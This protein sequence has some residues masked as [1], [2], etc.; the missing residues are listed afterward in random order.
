MDIFIQKLYLLPGLFSY[1][2]FLGVDLQVKKKIVLKDLQD[3]LPK[4]LPIK[5]HQCI[6]LN[7][8]VLQF[9]IYIIF[10]YSNNSQ[11]F[12]FF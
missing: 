10:T 1:N 12:I 3:I 2:G 4:L 11:K 8:C 5:S 6:L 7:G 9:F